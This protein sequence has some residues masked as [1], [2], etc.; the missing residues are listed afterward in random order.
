MGCCSLEIAN[1]RICIMAD[2]PWSHEVI[3]LSL[4][5]T[6]DQIVVYSK[7]PVFLHFAYP[8]REEGSDM[9]QSIKC[10]VCT[11]RVWPYILIT[12]LQTAFI[13][14]GKQSSSI[15]A[16]HSPV[17]MCCTA[18]ISVIIS[19]SVQVWSVIAAT[20]LGP[21][22][23]ITATTAYIFPGMAS[24]DERL[25]PVGAWWDWSAAAYAEVPLGCC[26]LSCCT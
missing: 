20:R 14:M 1:C 7:T 18:V 21:C 3:A 6:L 5:W 2:I 26:S 16:V 12:R 9:K 4:I 10:V 23:V 17:V 11:V 8:W 15:F 25:W 13:I 19:A 24:L 22:V